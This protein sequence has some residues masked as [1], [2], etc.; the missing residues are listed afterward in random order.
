MQNW[1]FNREKA[2]SQTRR[3]N[4]PSSPMNLQLYSLYNIHYTMTEDHYLTGHAIRFTLYLNHSCKYFP[5]QEN[6]N[7]Y[8]VCTD[9]MVCSYQSVHV[10]VHF[11]DLARLVAV[12]CAPAAWP[13]NSM[14]CN[15]CCTHMTMQSL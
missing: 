4:K 2:A 3:M 1:D 14:V 6:C 7:H 12:R 13:N 5:I 9:S 10:S 11:R 8:A 15:F